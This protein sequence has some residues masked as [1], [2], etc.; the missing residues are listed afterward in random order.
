MKTS[1]LIYDL[2][3]IYFVYYIVQPYCKKRM[4]S[5]RVRGS[6]EKIVK[7]NLFDDL[8]FFMKIHLPLYF[9]KGCPLRGSSCG[10]LR[11]RKV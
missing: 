8:L 1:P 5:I 4:T 10:G 11:H 7:V 9:R 2:K 6:A 3:R